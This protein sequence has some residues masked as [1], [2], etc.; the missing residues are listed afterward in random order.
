MKSVNSVQLG[1]KD[2]LIKSIQMHDEPVQESKR[3]ARVASLLKEF[4]M[5]RFPEEILFVLQITPS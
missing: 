3:S 1:G 5:T 2:I 4:H